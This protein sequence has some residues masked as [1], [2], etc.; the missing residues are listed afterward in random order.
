MIAARIAWSKQRVAKFT[1]LAGPCSSSC[2]AHIDGP[3]ATGALPH[4]HKLATLSGELPNGGPRRL[5]PA[6]TD[7]LWLCRCRR[8]QDVA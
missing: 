2:E 7:T 5:S 3:A 4:P 8:F 6:W 1:Q